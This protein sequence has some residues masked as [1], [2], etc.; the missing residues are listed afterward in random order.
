MHHRQD[1]PGFH[2][3]KNH[4]GDARDFAVVVCHLNAG[5]ARER[6]PQ[7]G[8]WFCGD[9]LVWPTKACAKQAANDRT[10]EFARADEPE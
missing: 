5:F 3:E 1:D 4:L 8:G 9:D 10:G 7:L 2:A 6:L